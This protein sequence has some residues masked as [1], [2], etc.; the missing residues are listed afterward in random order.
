MAP[1]NTSTRSTEPEEPVPTSPTDTR[2][3]PPRFEPITQEDD[4][5][6]YQEREVRSSDQSGGTYGITFQLIQ[7][8]LTS[9]LRA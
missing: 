6:E 2:G 8:V 7:D 9:L 1:D 5:E 3:R 4:A